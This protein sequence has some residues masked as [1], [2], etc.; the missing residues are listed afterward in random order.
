MRYR[1]T[2]MHKKVNRGCF[3]LYSTVNNT[4]ISNCKSAYRPE[5][6]GFEG[7][8]R[9]SLKATSLLLYYIQDHTTS[10]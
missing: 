9:L 3:T 10:V 7:T 2:Q 5:C 1:D 4:E 8:M 6:A